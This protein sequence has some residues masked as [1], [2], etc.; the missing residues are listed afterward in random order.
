MV[1]KRKLAIPYTSIFICMLPKKTQEII[2]SDIE[3]YARDNDYVLLWDEET[4]DYVAMTRRFSDISEIYNDTILEFC[5]ES[6]D[7][8]V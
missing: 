4:N 1:K 3:D 2:R 5:N 6:E 7:T 8:M